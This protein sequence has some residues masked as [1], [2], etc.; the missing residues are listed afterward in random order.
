MKRILVCGS[1]THD[2]AALVEAALDDEFRA[3][4][5]GLRV[6]H[7]GIGG[8]AAV[9]HAWV[10]GQR[11]LGRGVQPM[12][13]PLTPEEARAPREFRSRNVRMLRVGKPQL[14]LAFPGDEESKH[15]VQ[16][17]RCA[18]IEVVEVGEVAMGAL[19]P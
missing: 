14:V 1:R 8:V 11:A 10:F 17:A 4:P 7:G 3:S 15:L 19:V 2:Y 9:A 6:I 5:I 16:L 13:F 18:G 12:E